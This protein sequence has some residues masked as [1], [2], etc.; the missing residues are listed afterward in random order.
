[1]WIRVS[2]SR[3]R[4]TGTDTCFIDF[5]PGTFCGFRVRVWSPQCFTVYESGNW[6]PWLRPQHMRWTDCGDLAS[7]QSSQAHRYWHWFYCV[8]FGVRVRVWS[9]P[10]LYGVWVGELES[11]VATP[12]HAVNRLCGSGFQS[13]VSGT[14]VRVEV[15]NFIERCNFEF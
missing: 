4:H 2:V 1:M 14:Q 13:V 15:V 5:V 3:L 12:A 10:V 9:P 8:G 7:N 6:S 11:L